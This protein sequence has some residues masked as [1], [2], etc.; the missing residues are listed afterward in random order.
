MSKD[1]TTKEKQVYGNVLA[2]LAVPEITTDAP[3]VIAMVGLVGSGKSAVAPALAEKIGAVVVTGDDIRVALRKEEESYEYTREIMARLAKNV[4]LQQ[5]S[6]VL[7]GDYIRSKKREQ[8]KEVL[9]STDATLHFVRTLCE[10]DVM[11]QRL[12]DAEYVP[13]PD[14]LFGSATI[15]VREM[16]RRTPW[17]YKW[18]DE[19]GGVWNPRELDF[20]LLGEVDMTDGDTLSQQIEGLIAKL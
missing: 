4:A 11:I 14:G 5:G 13:R 19:R 20:P 6:V 9:G 10:R 12:I 1:L 7:D 3:V 2:S 15:A 16:W 8:L 17:H 18:S